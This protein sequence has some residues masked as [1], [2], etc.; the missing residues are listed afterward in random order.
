MAKID[1]R[2]TPPFWVGQL[3]HRDF[4]KGAKEATYYSGFIVDIAVFL[5]TAKATI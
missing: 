3:I 5:Y 2:I 1:I 4:T